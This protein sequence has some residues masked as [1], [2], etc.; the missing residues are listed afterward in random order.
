MDWVL[1]A[2]SG[3]L[4]VAAFPGSGD[5]AWL[6]FV[7]L[8]PLFVALDG[9]G[10]RRGAW[11]G[12]VSGVAFWL[13]TIAWPAPSVLRFGGVALSR[14]A[15]TVVVVVAFLA[16]YTA[17]FGGLLTGLPRRRAGAWV[18]GAGCLWVALELARTYLLTG[19][20]WN[21]LAYSQY[22]DRALL[23]LAAVTGAYGVSF[24]VLVVNA[25][26]ARLVLA[27]ARG[28]RPRDA[29]G[30]LVAGAG[31][32][33]VALLVGAAV[34]A[35]RGDATVPVAVAQG[36]IDQ[37]VKWDPAYRER[38]LAVY[39]ALTRDAARGRPALVVWPETAVPLLR[40]DD[41]RWAVVADTARAAGAFLL[42]GAPDRVD[43]R[44]RNSVFL[45]GPD[46]ALAGRYDKRHLLPFGEYLPRALAFLRVVGAG[47]VSEFTAGGGAPVLATPFGR[48]A[49]VVCFE[50]IF[51]D[52]VRARV[53]AGADVV[54]NLTNDAWFGRSPTARQHLAAA[55]FRAVENH[56]WL[57]RAANSGI[58]ALVAPDGRIVASAGL[59]RRDVV[60][61][62]VAPR[63]GTTFYTR[64]GD[65]FAWLAVGLSAAA[66]APRRREG[67]RRV[68]ETLTVRDAA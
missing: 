32:L 57:V 67:R 8:V 29:L 55:V 45:L 10:R 47:A 66:L 56:V 36:N 30:A 26:L 46:G 20:P 59:F 27:L 31:T 3:L 63:H 13:P 22:R 25:S 44:P 61:G 11:L 50:V 14:G 33:A 49:P 58:S 12:F 68:P 52:E 60:A 6:A 34:P 64:Y 16:L 37:S 5:G 65:V 62:A 18:L 42:V 39:R 28:P 51:P 41:P 54:V 48:L 23:P 21:L 17:A 19:F 4:L 15:V 40:H 1:A 38:T 53:A 24:V 7:A 43:G 2:A 35:P 9:A